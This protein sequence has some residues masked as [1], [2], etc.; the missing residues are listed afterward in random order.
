MTS[1]RRDEPSYIQCLPS[2]FAITRSIVLLTPNGLLQR[3]Q[4]NGSSSFRMR[5]GA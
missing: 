2:S 5:A 4:Q 1:S 3:M